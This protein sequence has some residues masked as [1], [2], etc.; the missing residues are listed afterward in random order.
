MEAAATFN[1]IF[2]SVLGTDQKEFS[3]QLQI[4]PDLREQPPFLAMSTNYCDLVRSGLIT[5]HKGKMGALD[6]STMKVTS[7][8]EE[9]SDVSA[10]VL[11]TGFD[12]APLLDFLPP[13]VLDA[14]SFSPSHQSLPV[15]LAF[16]GTH[17]PAYPTL[18]FVG[19][20]RS[21]YWGVME[22]QARFMAHLWAT[23][24]QSQMLKN[25]LASDDTIS[26]TIALRTDPRLSQFPMGDY[27]FLMHEFAKAL[28]MQISPP[29]ETPRLKNGKSMDI[30]TP[31]RYVSPDATEAQ[32]AEVEKNLA[33][34]H[35][36]ALAGLTR[37]GFVSHAVF[38]SLLGEW[39]L[40][41]DLV[42]RLPSHPSGRFVGTARFLLR[43]GTADGRGGSGEGEEALGMEYLYIE[44]GNF[45]ASNGMTFRA[46]R[47]Y[48]YRYDEARDVMSVWFARTDDHARADYLFHNL[49]FLAPPPEEEA[50]GGGSRARSK[51]WQAR[52]SHLCIEDLYDVKYEFNFKAVNL[53]SWKIGYSVKGPKKDYTID[54]VYSRK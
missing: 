11:A 40:E 38:R 46:T 17:H 30:L 29:R 50:E 2:E 12:G 15:A 54:G 42:S 9:I 51:G 45:S 21:P 49:E 48:I 35:E 33:A 14:I 37:A 36:T 43:A 24:D 10:V 34:T 6:G 47:R 1:S 22:M 31:A 19:Y 7:P 28:G 27:P 53:E 23:P 41:R 52:A 20:Y 3:P 39:R 16:H 44:D 18:G 5:I 8:E 32:R 4:G 13:D 25:A 26:R